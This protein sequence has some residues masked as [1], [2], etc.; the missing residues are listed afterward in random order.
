M[1]ELELEILIPERM[2]KCFLKLFEGRHE[3]FRNKTPSVRAEI[4]S[5][6]RQFFDTNIL[7]KGYRLSLRGYYSPYQQNIYIMG[8]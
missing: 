3:G 2:K 4:S 7:L 5:P 8:L 6:V 1:S